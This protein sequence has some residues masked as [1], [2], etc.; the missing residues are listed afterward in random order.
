MKQAN[1][2]QKT[3]KRQLRTAGSGFRSPVNQLLHC[4]VERKTKIRCTPQI[5]LKTYRKMRSW[6]MAARE[7][8][9]AYGVDLPHVTWRCYAIK[10]RDIA[11]L[12]TRAA[13]LLGPRT[14][15]TCKTNPG[16]PFAKF[17]K[18][19]RPCDLKRWRNLCDAKKYKAAREL[20][21]EV[22]SRPIK[23]IMKVKR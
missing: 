1:I 2:A 10:Q 16:A 6:R 4:G 18:R 23:K 11:D 22:Y 14:C 8:N 9:S 7:L 21:D 12:E 15:P 13:L 3:Q 17:I 5:V 20:L 19:L